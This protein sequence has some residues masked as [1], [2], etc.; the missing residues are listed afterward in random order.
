VR[1]RRVHILART[2]LR[3]TLCGEILVGV[4]PPREVETTTFAEAAEDP[5]NPRYCKRCQ[6]SLARQLQ[7]IS[8][9]ESQDAEVVP[10]SN[11]VFNE[12]AIDSPE[13][14]LFAGAQDALGRPLFRSSLARL[15]AYLLDPSVEN[16][17]HVRTIVIGRQRGLQ[18]VWQAVAAIDPLYRCDRDVYPDPILFARAIRAALMVGGSKGRY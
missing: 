9:E 14:S 4:S 16:W 18:T 15:R 3:Q 11:T 12:E 13:A 7:I 6:K 8:Y 1:E 5:D 10:F 17:K 2:V